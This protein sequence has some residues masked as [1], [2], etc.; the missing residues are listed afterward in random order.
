MLG[1]DHPSREHTLIALL[2]VQVMYHLT[3]PRPT[4]PV[5]IVPMQAILMVPMAMAGDL[6]MAEDLAGAEEEDGGKLDNRALGAV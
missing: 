1:Q 6:A 5:T 3:E 4:E 2:T